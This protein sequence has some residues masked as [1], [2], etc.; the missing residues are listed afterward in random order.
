MT[1]A[2]NPLTLFLLCTMP[3][4]LLACGSTAELPVQAG[5]GPN[6]ALT[7][8]NPPWLPTVNVATAVG[9]QEGKTPQA[10]ADTQVIAFAQELEH[11]RWLYVLPN[12]DVLVAETAA[13]P[14]PDQ[15]FN[16]RGWIM[17]QVLEKAGAAVPSA[18][19]ITLLRDTNDDGIADERYPFLEDLNSPF[20]MVL[21]EADLYVANTDALLR[22]DYRDG[23]TRIRQA[24][25]KLVDLPAGP[26]NHHWTKNVV[27]SPD[28]GKLYVSVGSNSNIAENGLDE[29][30]GRAAIW[31]VDRETGE[32][33]VYAQGLRNP[34]GMTWVS[35]DN[36][37]WTTVNE[38]D[39]LGGDLVPDYMTSVEDGGFY[40]WPYS[41]FGQHVDE[42]VEPQA[43]ELVEQAIKPDYALGPHTASLGLTYSDNKDSLQHFGRGMF[44]GQHGSWNRDP[45]S[46]YKVIFVPFFEGRPAGMPKDVLTGFINEKGEAMGRPVG[47]VFDTEGDLLVADDVGNTVWRVRGTD[48]EGMPISVN[49]IWRVAAR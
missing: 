39:E 40:G 21:V 36:R 35:Y 30:V 17:Q 22:F 37:L 29:E 7:E 33:R 46:G 26:I 23:Q 27:A 4:V 43:P 5:M 20:G 13:P 19:R 3:F 1:R 10:A 14:K 31:E 16:I 25:E 6:P 47:V 18:N 45:R 44:I 12:G 24:G 9:W 49:Q 41:Y 8:P 2:R 48:T 28:G 11:P 32:H 38:R 34:V 42:R 15:G